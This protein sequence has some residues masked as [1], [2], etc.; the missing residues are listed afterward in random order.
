MRW[1]PVV[2]VVSVLV[3]A[4][5]AGAE[6]RPRGR[7]NS[8]RIDALDDRISAIEGRKDSV[9]SGGPTRPLEQRV[10]ELEDQLKQATA[11]VKLLSDRVH[12]LEAVGAAPAPAADPAP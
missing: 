4:C 3:T 9:L 8:L 5:G 1:M 6:M 2:G 11:Q 10:R 12:A 7:R